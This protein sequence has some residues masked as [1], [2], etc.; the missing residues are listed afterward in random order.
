MKNIDEILLI[1]NP[2]P[3]PH[4][5]FSVFVE[6]MINV[7]ARRDGLQAG[8]GFAIDLSGFSGGRS[9]LGVL[10]QQVAALTIPIHVETD[11]NH[12][13]CE[14]LHD[15]C[16]HAEIGEFPDQFVCVVFTLREC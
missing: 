9:L 11:N 3:H 6:F 15:Y 10:N 8:F 13:L 2:N 5:E 14:S 16:K 7:V 12:G 1:I 4:S